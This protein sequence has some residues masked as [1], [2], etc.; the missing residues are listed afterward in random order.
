MFLGWHQPWATRKLLA[1]MHLITAALIGLAVG[2]DTA[3]PGGS[4]SPRD[5]RTHAGRWL[6]KERVKMEDWWCAQDG[7]MDTLPCI[8]RKMRDASPDVR[9]EM[10]EKM[11]SDATDG[12]T[13]MQNKLAS[14]DDMHEAWCKTHGETTMCQKW[15]ENRDKRLKRKAERLERRPSTDKRRTETDSMHEAYCTSEHADEAPCLLWNLRQTSRRT[16]RDAL[17]AKLKM[18]EPGINE[19]QNAAMHE[20]WCNDPQVDRDEM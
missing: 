18:L 9:K 10:R 6:H 5:G 1:G 20:F 7:K 3:A 19:E 17:K 13:K 15:A 2:G 12:A 16:E 8:A 11:G 14:H 4:A